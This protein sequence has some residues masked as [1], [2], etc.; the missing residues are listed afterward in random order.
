MM[1]LLESRHNLV[2]CEME[3]QLENHIK[4][5]TFT[6]ISTPKNSLYQKGYTVSKKMGYHLLSVFLSGIALC[7]LK[8]LVSILVHLDFV[9]IL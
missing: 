3:M 7:K 2:A 1:Q 5:S 9:R 4:N 6:G 8:L